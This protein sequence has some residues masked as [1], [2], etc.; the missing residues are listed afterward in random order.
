[1]SLILKSNTKYT[2]SSS[3][4]KL[5]QLTHTQAD[6]FSSYKSRVLADGGEIVSDEAV[7]KAYNFLFNNNLIGRMSCCAA[8]VYGIKKNSA[9]RV[10][11]LYSLDGSD[12]ICEVFGTGEYPTI[13]EDNYL[14]INDGSTQP[15][16]S[17]NRCIVRTENKQVFNESNQIGH[18]FVFKPIGK[19]IKSTAIALSKW[20]NWTWRDDPNINVA[21]Y[22]NSTENS[23]YGKNVVNTAEESIISHTHASPKEC[24]MV[25]RI[26]P[27]NTTDSFQLYVQGIMRRSTS[28]KIDPDIYS[29]PLH[30]I[31]G[32][33]TSISHDSYNK[34]IHTQVSCL[35]FVKDLYAGAAIEINNFLADNY[36]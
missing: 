35:W 13:T 34:G 23:I 32:G 27:S 29:T 28:G 11:K 20:D 21:L 9:G 16:T 31:Y 2:G 26:D 7:L 8:P 5:T 24:A 12:M 22:D 19:R 4:P 14:S 30:V 33:N 15:T 36:V 1:M 10:V 25:L 3:Y 6:V 17:G 18:A